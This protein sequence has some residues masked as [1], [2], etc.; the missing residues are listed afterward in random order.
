MLQFYV[1]TLRL[2]SS[3]RC[4]SPKKFHS[5]IF[6]DRKARAQEAPGRLFVAPAASAMMMRSALSRSARRMTGKNP[7]PMAHAHRRGGR[8]QAPKQKNAQIAPKIEPARP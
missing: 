1:R 6:V 3:I 5:K 7:L 4:P 2:A 8:C